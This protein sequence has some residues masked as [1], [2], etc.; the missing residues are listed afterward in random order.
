MAIRKVL[1]VAGVA[2]TLCAVASPAYAW[3]CIRVSS[4]PQGLQSSS[5]HGQW[6]YLTFSDLVAGG[7]QNG[8]ID[9]TQVACVTAQWTSLGEPTSF[10]IGGGVAGAKGATTSGHITDSDFFE[11]AKNAPLKVMVNGKGVDHLDDALMLIVAACPST[12]N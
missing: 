10:A 5:Q 3:D 2:V 12:A 1:T 6:E 9:A 4:S 8:D 7:V 11:L